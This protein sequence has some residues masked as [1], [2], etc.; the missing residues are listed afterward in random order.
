MRTHKVWNSRG[1]H[2]ASI[3]RDQWGGWSGWTHHI[4]ITP[5]ASITGYRTRRETADALARRCGF[6][7]DHIT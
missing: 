4:G 7:V 6:I 5:G 1:D 2:V 3:E